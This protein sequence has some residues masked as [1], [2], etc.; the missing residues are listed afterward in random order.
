MTVE[1]RLTPDSR[2]RTIIGVAPSIVAFVGR[3]DQPDGRTGRDQR[4]R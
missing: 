2:V 1:V 3:A 4:L